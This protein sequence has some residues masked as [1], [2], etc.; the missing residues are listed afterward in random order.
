MRPENLAPDYDIHTGKST[1]T[2]NTVYGEV[3]TG[4]DWEKARQHYC[5]DHDQNMPI[6]LIFFGDKTHLDRHGCLAATPVMFTLSIFSR[7]ARCSPQF[8]RPLAYIPNLDYGLISKEEK[9][10]LNKLKDEQ[11]CLRTAFKSLVE[12]TKKKGRKGIRTTVANKEVVCKV[13]I[14]FIIG[15]TEGNNK[16]LGHYNCHGNTLCLIEI[17]NVHFAI[18][19]NQTQLAYPSPPNLYRMQEQ[20]AKLH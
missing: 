3:H 16:W 8:W 13:W 4:D 9:D 2:D 15:D 19:I 5:G 1:V 14:H 20:Q 6:G 18:W 10:P 17:A 11:Q 7:E 12:L